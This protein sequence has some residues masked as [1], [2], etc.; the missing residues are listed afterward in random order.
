MGSDYINQNRST[1][2]EIP[3]QDK[4]REQSVILTDRQKDQAKAAL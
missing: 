2:K 4:R 3:R 1:T